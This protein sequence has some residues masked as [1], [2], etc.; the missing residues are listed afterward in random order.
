MSDSSAH[1]EKIPLGYPSQEREGQ[2]WRSRFVVSS[3]CNSFSHLLNQPQELQA[4]C[5]LR[6]KDAAHDRGRH[7]SW[8][9]NTARRHTVMFPGEHHR[10]ISR[11]GDPRDLIGD[12]LTQSLLQL[13]A[14]RKLLGNAREFREAQH[15]VVGEVANGDLTPEGQ[16]MVLIAVVDK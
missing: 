9:T 11:P 15:V 14:M 4:G 2:L 8:G 7:A 10:Y 3:P 5:A 12:L 1:Y 6:A 16:E 13:Q